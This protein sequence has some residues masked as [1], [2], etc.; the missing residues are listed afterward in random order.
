[1]SSSQQCPLQVLSSLSLS[2]RAERS[3]ALPP[4]ARLSSLLVFLLRVV[5]PSPREPAILSSHLFSSPRLP[6][7]RL[8]QTP[9][10]CARHPI[11]TYFFGRH[12]PPR[13]CARRGPRE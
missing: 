12:T 9:D 2:A 8:P 13:V 4:A 7:C 6:R 11:Y 3:Y 10:P 1:M 5:C